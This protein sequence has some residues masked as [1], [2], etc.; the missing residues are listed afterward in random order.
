[1]IAR[2]A[3][4]VEARAW[5]GTRWQHQAR[6]K[7]I[8]TDCIGLVAG[9]ADALGVPE[10]RAFFAAPEWHNYGREPDA[11]MLLGGCDRFLDRVPVADARAGDVLVMR[12]AE[13]PQHFAIV[14]NDAPQRIIHAYA[15]A[16]RVV[17]HGLDALWRSRIV[18]A[19]RFRGI[20]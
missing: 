1:V 15:Q 10:A 7:G 12:F 4:V 5:V 18:R 14:S 2:G 6:L 9:V 8:G 13:N 3:V 16:R 19:Y 20:V 17:E 11:A